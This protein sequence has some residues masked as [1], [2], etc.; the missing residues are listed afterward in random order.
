MNMTYFKDEKG[1]IWAFDDEQVAAGYGSDMTPLTPEEVEAHLNPTPDYL[2]L[3]RARRDYLISYAT[4]RINPLQDLVDI[5]EA[6][7]DDIA[8]LKLWKTYRAA[9]GKADTKPGWPENPDWPL[10]PE[11]V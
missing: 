6:E 9:L 4:L 2:A 1:A 3:A 10:P 7:A 8:L 11:T 5:D